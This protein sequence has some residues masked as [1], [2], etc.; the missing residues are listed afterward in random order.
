MQSISQAIDLNAAVCIQTL[1]QYLLCDRQ[2]QKILPGLFR[3][4]DALLIIQ[5][6]YTI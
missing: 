6:Q 3:Q 2:V 5:L 1:L 4:K